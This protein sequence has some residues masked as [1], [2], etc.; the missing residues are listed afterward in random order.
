MSGRVLR[1]ESPV[2]REID[3]WLPWYA[4]GTL[5]DDERERT[6]MHLSRCV[7]CQ[8][9]LDWL[10]DLQSAA[11]EQVVF[12]QGNAE[13]ALNRL[14]RRLDAG[15]GRRL[16]APLHRLRNGWRRAPA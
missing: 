4:N 3:A 12:A 9:E 16:L 6:E 15:I 10:R 11:A 8:R 2:H 1:F 13:A 5:P 7:R 14:R